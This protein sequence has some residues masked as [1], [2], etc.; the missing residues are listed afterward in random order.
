MRHILIAV[1]E[2]VLAAGLEAILK[3][4]SFEISICVDVAT[5]FEVIQTSRPDVAI[6]DGMIAGTMPMIRD[7]R[8]LAPQCQLLLWGG[9]VSDGQTAEAIRLGAVAVLPANISPAHLIE[10]MDM[11]V[12]FPPLKSAPGA[13]VK[14]LCDPDERRLIALVSAGMNDDEIAAM[15]HH[16]KATVGRLIKS[17]S[18]RLGAKDR[19]ELVLYGLSSVNG[20][21]QNY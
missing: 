5:V 11:L 10:A 2:P 4:G 12:A 17:V 18:H 15:L 13:T 21:P 3:T 16:D 14:N 6:L 1:N 7:L 20:A 8:S 19:Y 9:R